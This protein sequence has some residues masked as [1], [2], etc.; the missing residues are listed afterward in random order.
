[1]LLYSLQSPLTLFVPDVLKA[2][3]TASPS[4]I[5]TLLS[6]LPPDEDSEHSH[7]AGLIRDAAAGMYVAAMDSVCVEASVCLYA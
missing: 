5:S 2:A 7:Q 1:M 6:Q 3:G 4:F